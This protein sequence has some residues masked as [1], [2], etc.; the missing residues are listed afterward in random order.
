M[1]NEVKEPTAPSTKAMWLEAP[2]GQLDTRLRDDVVNR[3]DDEPTAIQLLE[4]LDKVKYTGGGSGFTVQSLKI[5]YDFTLKQEGKTHEDLV[6]LATWR[7][8]WS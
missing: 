6:P 8:E 5:M 1:E 3:W 7:T 2:D 4:L